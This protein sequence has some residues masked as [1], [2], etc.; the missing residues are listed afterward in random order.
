MMPA[1]DRSP[2]LAFVDAFKADVTLP[3]HHSVAPVTI[4]ATPDFPYPGN[5]VRRTL[6]N[7]G[8][9]LSAP[10][11]SK[12]HGTIRREKN[13]SRAPAL[14]PQ[15]ERSGWPQRV[16]SAGAVLLSRPGQSRL[17]RPLLLPTRHNA[18]TSSP[19]VA[20]PLSVFVAENEEWTG[21]EH[22]ANPVAGSAAQVT[23][24]ATAT[25]DTSRSS[26][27]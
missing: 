26:E 22:A 23:T 4:G 19:F 2:A 25:R 24:K 18:G 13:Q 21:R 6:N 8:R 17:A 16:A 1:R 7:G 3:S 12:P 10:V 20:D 14:R 5:P 27:Q 11:R 15:A 9:G